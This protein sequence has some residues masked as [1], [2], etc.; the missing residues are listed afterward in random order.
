VSAAAVLADGLSYRFPA[1]TR[2]V[3]RRVSWEVEVG[4]VTLVV[5]PSSAGKTTL[6]RCLNGLIPHFHGGNFGGDVVVLGA[7]TRGASPRDFAASVGVVFQ[8]PEAQF[9]TDRVEDEIVFGLENLGYQRGVM[10]LRLEETL[11]LLGIHHLRQREVAT[12]SGGERQRVALA[13]AL[14]TR[15]GMLV[16]DEPTSQLDPLAAHDVLAAVERLNRDLGMT[17]VLSEHR[18]DRVL[19]FA[20]RL[21]LVERAGLRE[22]QVREQL[23]HMADVPPLVALARSQGW[24]P[25]PVTVR[26]ARRFLPD[27]FDSGTMDTPRHAP[28]DVLACVEGLRHRYGPR[29]SLNDVSFSARQGE[30]IAL[31]GRNGSGKTTLLK[32]LMGLLRPERGRVVLRGSDIA[33]VPV[34]QIAG[35][36][37]YVPQHPTTILHQETLLEELRYTGRVQGKPVEPMALL[38]RLGIAEHAARH[39][40]DLSGGERQRA[41]LAAIAVTEPAV[42][43]LDEPTRGLPGAD[44]R[45]LAGFVRDYAAAGRTVI[46][47]THDVEFAAVAADRV[48]LLAGGEL[49]ADGS[50]REVLAG[51]LAFGT[52][53]NRLLGGQVLTLA[54]AEAVLRQPG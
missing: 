20:E 1:G 51:S 18:L 16:L 5:G 13:A 49:I 47:A 8:D 7:N 33:R 37:G 11:D 41:A 53:L 15:P 30:V 29:V 50:A 10:R 28:G 46:V 9:I 2:D 42:L 31:L 26:E 35:T 25:L 3:L 45:V 52:Q 24:E 6:L 32:H 43:L 19:P 39:P 22:G 17:I 21:V 34:Q 48:L 23:A 38:E 36:A 12:L 40:L 27:E 44:K 4:S 54:D 14:V